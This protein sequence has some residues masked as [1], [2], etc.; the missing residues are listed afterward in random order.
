MYAVKHV[1]AKKTC[2]NSTAYDVKKPASIKDVAHHAGVSIST[3]SNVLSGKR[4]V[5]E[6]LKKRVMK[7]VCALDYQTN[8]IGRQLKTGRS[9]Q[10]A[11]LVPSVTSIFF[12][13]VLKSVQA[14]ADEAGY[15]VSVF[16]TK[17]QLSQERRII[18]MLWS[19]GFD[20]ILLD[21]CAD[22]DLPETAE[23]I[24]FLE[25]LNSG[26]NPIRIVCVET[27]ISGKLDAV[28]VNDTDGIF[29]STEY[30]I[31]KGRKN[32]AYIAAPNQYIH[33]KKRKQGFFAALAMHGIP[34]EEAIV[35]EGNFSCASGYAAMERIIAHNK[36]I[37]AIVSANDQMAIGAML[38][39]KDRGIR[40]PED[41]SVIGFNGNA[42]GSLIFPSL[43]TVRVPKAE[44][45]S[46]AFD[47]F[48]RRVS[49][50]DSPHMQIQL[51]GNLLIRQ[52]TDPEVDTA[53]DMDW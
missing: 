22:V 40:I 23:Y 11:F 27:A 48:K 31:K 20:G 38:C 29:K 5:S 51:E 16:G 4:S 10:I 7:S 42:P 43:S 14:A 3:V 15:T 33:A 26:S 2:I 24:E 46:L 37:D 13:N 19:Q 39:L 50:D 44:M 1:M 41:V 52:S 35:E 18:N 12:P 47:L 21:S 30:L 49:G 25:G 28:V 9:M 17:G 8:P 53:W 45:G 6:E 36:P 32:I 34:A